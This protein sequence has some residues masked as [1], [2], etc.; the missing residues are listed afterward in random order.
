MPFLH[1]AG[2]GTSPNTEPPV[3]NADLWRD[4]IP[5]YGGYLSIVFGIAALGVNAYTFFVAGAQAETWYLIGVNFFLL[6][7]VFAL[8]QSLYNKQGRLLRLFRNVT[9]LKAQLD[10]RDVAYNDISKYLQDLFHRRTGISQQMHKT[11]QGQRTDGD[12]RTDVKE[13]IQYLLNQTKLIFDKYTE[14]DTSTCLKMITIHRELNGNFG[15]NGESPQEILTFDRD[16]SSK[17]TR[18]K[19]DKEQE[20]MEY[21][22]IRNT[23]FREIMYNRGRDNYF[24]HNDLLELERQGLY[25]NINPYWKNHYKATAVHAIK[26]PGQPRTEGVIG[27]LCIDNMNGGFDDK[28]SKHMLSLLSDTLYYA[29]STASVLLRHSAASEE[30][31]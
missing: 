27:F 24:Y 18:G 16:H 3:R 30:D 6:V 12:L 11:I 21:L 29:F 20:T 7:G 4:I 10:S 15:R 23:A 1:R 19:V 2:G 17:E 22:C 13:Y 9:Y 25:E 14:Y 28:F 5:R 26:D 8:F 31:R